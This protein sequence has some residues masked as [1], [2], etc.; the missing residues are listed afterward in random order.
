MKSFRPQL[1]F[2][3]VY[4]CLA[5]IPIINWKILFCVFSRRYDE[6]DKATWQCGSWCEYIFVVVFS[7]ILLLASIVLTVFWIIYYKQGYSL[8]DKGKLFNFHPTLMIGGYITL[9]GFC[10]FSHANFFRQSSLIYH[11]SA[12][13]LYRICRCCS[14]LIVKLCHVFFHAC[15]IPCIV[16]GFLAVWEWKN[17]TNTPHFYSLHSWLGLITSGLFAF[18]FVLGFFRWV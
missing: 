16:I 3:F 5:R 6:D 2:P 1:W 12:V 8:E 15:S 17:E 14:H 7:A 4:L 10:E 9:S 11:F 13:L 18:Q